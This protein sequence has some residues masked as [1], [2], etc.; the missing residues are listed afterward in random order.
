MKF[1]RYLYLF[2][3]LSTCLSAGVSHADTIQRRVA[4]GVNHSLT[5]KEDGTLWS[6]GSNNY[7]QLGIGS[8]V[9]QWFPAQVSSMSNVAAA[10]AGTS[11]SLAAKADGTVWA[12]GYNAY[13][14]LGDGTTTP[15]PSR[16]PWPPNCVK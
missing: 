2:V 6:W 12:W 3:L 8:T 16:L 15:T 4:A 13:G 1:P 10:A 14:Q 5:L 7:G 11:H 9:D